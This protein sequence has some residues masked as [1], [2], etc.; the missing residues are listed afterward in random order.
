MVKEKN[1]GIEKLSVKERLTDLPELIRVGEA[2][3]LATTN[4]INSLKQEM[5]L[6]ESALGFEIRKAIIIETIDSK[7]KEKQQFK[8]DTERGFELSKRLGMNVEY[9]TWKKEMQEKYQKK[10]EDEI[11][12]SYMK[13]IF[14][15]AKAIARM[16]DL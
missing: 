3:F 1:N 13:R 5:S 2:E 15:A 10:S 11:Q 4:K 16:G 6:K 9:Q 12:L 7:P 14:S 8:N